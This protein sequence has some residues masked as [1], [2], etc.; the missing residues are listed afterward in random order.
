MGAGDSRAH[1]RVDRREKMTRKIKKAIAVLAIA[2]F[3]AAAFA[4]GNERPSEPKKGR[5]LI[6]GS[7]S[8]KTPI[9]IKAREAEFSEHRNFGA[10]YGTTAQTK[11]DFFIEPTFQEKCYNQISYGMEGYFYT[12]VKVPKDGKIHMEDFEVGMFCKKNPWHKFA[13]PATFTASIPD[14][15][16]YVYIGDFEYD[17]D[18]AL[19]VVGFNHYD[20]FDSAKKQIS[21]DMGADIDLYRANLEFN[22]TSS[23][24]IDAK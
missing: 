7:L 11:N 22:D 14:D 2:F 17:L 21:R 15:A 12:E 13:L 9:D 1:G 5:V 3:A 24:S 6:I 10:A 4:S 20:K 18:Y 19:R 23:S 16:V 8:Y